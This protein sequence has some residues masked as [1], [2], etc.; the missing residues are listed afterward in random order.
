MNHRLRFYFPFV[1][2]TSFVLALDQWTKWLVLNLVPEGTRWLPD[3]LQF[4]D[5]Y[6]GLLRVH[7]SG[8]AFGTFQNGNLVFVVLAILVVIA[9]IYYYPR[10][11]EQDVAL[12]IAMALQTGGALGNLID[13]LRF[14]KVTD[15]ISVGTFAVFNV[16]DSA[17]TVG[18]I[19][20]LI[21]VWLGE[22]KSRRA[23]PSGDKPV[24]V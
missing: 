23:Q 3:S 17:I 5:G 20:L 15:F 14:G 12:R 24:Q 8:A 19:V 18:V 11:S 6:A 7:N 9:I 21:G 16:A 10:V 2:I 13:R 1:L 4:L 22:R